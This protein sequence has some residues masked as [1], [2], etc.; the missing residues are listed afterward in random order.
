MTP[1]TPPSRAKSNA[2]TLV[3]LIVVMAI[4]AILLVIL[5]PALFAAQKQKDIVR[6]ATSL[7]HLGF[8]VWSYSMDHRDLMPDYYG[9]PSLSLDTVAMVRPNGSR[10]NLGLL[11]EY[12]TDPST[13]YCDAGRQAPTPDLAFDTPE[14]PW[15]NGAG[16]PGSWLNAGFAARFEKP[17]LTS[18]QRSTE[19]YT[20]KVVF[21][22]FL[23][24]NGYDEDSR[25]H[26]TIYATHDGRGCNLLF[27]D[28]GVHWVL[29][30]A[31]N[32]MRPVN[33]DCPSATEMDA[34]YQLLDI[35]PAGGGGQPLPHDDDD[36]HPQATHPEHDDH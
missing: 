6:C 8:G 31:I 19:L 22:D 20:N 7:H 25:F 26:G 17:S 14:N 18:A 12:I 2:F 15:N 35:L 11:T 4:V 32:S 1:R 29:A 34:Y 9:D 27:G 21:T 5:L 23:G 16:G 30:T 33:H 3:E 13:F 24:V 36:D 10:V 28:G